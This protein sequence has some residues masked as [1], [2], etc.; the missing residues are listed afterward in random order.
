MLFQKTIS[1]NVETQK[2]INVYTGEEISIKFESAA[3]NSG[4]VFVVNGERTKA[5][6]D[7][8]KFFNRSIF[9]GKIGVTEHLLSPIYALGIDNI[10]IKMD[11]LKEPYACPGFNGMAYEIINALNSAGIVAQ[12]APKKYLTVGKK[13]FIKQKNPEKKDS[14]IAEPFDNFIIEY[15]AFYSHSEVGEQFFSFEVSPENFQKNL[16]EARSPAFVQDGGLEN[17]CI[18]EK[19]HLL[20]GN[21]RGARY[22]GQEFVRHKVLDFLGT[23]ALLGRQFKNTRFK[24]NMSGHEFDLYVL[25]KLAKGKCFKEVD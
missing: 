23:L 24:V 25:K 11:F 20:I 10:V 13:F 12:A 17:Y 19:T 22:G 18:S 5:E 15:R 7:S 9:V 14:I 1:K 3:E 6:L 21:S 16:M 8:A 2:G 4:I